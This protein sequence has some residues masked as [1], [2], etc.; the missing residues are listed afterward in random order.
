MATALKDVRI[1]LS[2]PR[3]F[4]EQ[5]Y[6]DGA[7]V[8]ATSRKVIEVH[9]PATGERLGSVPSLGRNEVRRAVEAAHA[10]FDSWRRTTAKERSV[11]L[12]RWF[13]LMIEHQEDLALI[14]TREQGKP[15]AEAKGEVVYAASFI[16]WY[17]EEAKRIYGDTIPQTVP[18]RRILV[19][20][21][22]VGVCASITPWNF[23]AAMITRK[24]AP[25]LAAGCTMVAKPAK[26][27]P[28]SALALAEL[29]ERAGFPKGVFN[30]VTGSAGEVADE[31]T[32]NKL[33]RKLSFTGSTEVGKLLLKKCADT[34]KRVS[35]ELGGHAP[36][37]VFDDADIDAAV[38]GA[39]AC[40][41][42]NSGQTC[43]CTNRIY[44][45]DGVFDAFAE[46][47]AAAAAKLSVGP[48]T[49][50]GINVGPLIDK[51]AVK[52]VE[53]HIKDATEKG[54]KVVTGGKPH[55][56]GGLFFEPT[57]LA[58]CSTE[59]L[60]S[61]EETFGPVAPLFR[62]K[63][64]AEV[65][66]LAND[67]DYGLAGYF[68]ARDL[69]RVFRVAEALEVGLL[70]V[71][72]GVIATEVAPFGGVKESGIGREGS[73]YGIDEYLEI[74]YVSLGGIS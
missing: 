10:A 20:K 50:P 43:V 14:M 55:S 58:P 18:S 40:K 32:E 39:I 64:E 28:F 45:Q 51:A 13:D 52:K 23:P 15:L 31:L 60:I 12:R 6:V 3:L 66:K 49:E 29:A 41:F 11:I 65:I 37:I 35:M 5:C 59:M 71:N 9:D 73:K 67:S 38:Q 48:G 42:R 8:D 36:F 25:G 56:R 2:D 57:I 53:E 7:W 22:P 27:T 70:G 34:V 33:V 44:V 54:A 1:H 72:D 19:L 46:K 69:G 26:Y 30:V 16:E 24:C 68:Y 17:A 47:F 62:F 61:H 74:K 63:D 4:R 21:Q